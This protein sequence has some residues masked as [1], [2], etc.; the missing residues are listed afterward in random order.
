MFSVLERAED[1]SAGLDLTNN[2]EIKPEEI[3]KLWDER[4]SAKDDEVNTM[5][6]CVTYVSTMCGS[7]PVMG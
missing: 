3:Q 2:Q 4:K 7:W 5:A 6:D 1:Q